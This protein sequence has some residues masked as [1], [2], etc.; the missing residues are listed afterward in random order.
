VL[1]HAGIFAQC[2]DCQICQIR[3]CG[4]SV[5]THFKNVVATVTVFLVSILAANTFVICNSKK[6]TAQLPYL[7][8]WKSLTLG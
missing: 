2:L 5:D 3:K 6:I 8:G 7:Q 1:L 4:C